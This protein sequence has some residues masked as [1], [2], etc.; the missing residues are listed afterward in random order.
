[1][2]IE[3][4]VTFVTFV[5]VCHTC[6]GRDNSVTRLVRR[7]KTEKGGGVPLLYILNQINTLPPKTPMARKET[8]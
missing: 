6:H 2:K 8:I 1:V 7:E 5:T 3:A 4:K